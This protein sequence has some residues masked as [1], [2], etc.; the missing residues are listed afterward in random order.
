MPILEKLSKHKHV[1]TALV[2]RGA[3]NLGV[4]LAK[5]LIEQGAFVILIDEYTQ[6]KKR[7]VSS[8]LNKDLFSFVDIS[9]TKSI[10][11]S[12]VKLDYIFYLNHDVYEPDEKVTT[13]EFLEK[14][15]T[16]DRLLELGVEKNSRFLLTSSI[17][18]HEVLQSE[19]DA[20]LNV[21]LDDNSLSYTIL[22]VQRYAENLTWEYYKR[23]G[24]DTRIIRIGEILGEGIDLERRT[25][26]VQYINNAISGKKIQIEGDGLENLYFVYILDA[27][28]GL[29][30]AQFTAK[31][32]GKIYSLVIPRDITILNLAYKILDL[33]PRA[34][35]INFVDKKSKGEL[36]IYKPAKNLNVIGWK[37]R[38]SFERALANTIDFAYKVSGRKK[39]VEKVKKDALPIS[40]KLEG[41]KRGKKKKN[42]S[43]KDVFIN[44]FFEVKEETPARSVLDSIQYKSYKKGVLDDA[45]E[46]KVN[47]RVNLAD[48][49]DKKRPKRS[50]LRI[51]A[52]KI[53][54]LFEI[55]KNS[56]RSLTVWKL[57]SYLSAMMLFSVLYLLFFV[58]VAKVVY[59]SGVTYIRINSAFEASQDWQFTKASEDLNRV[60]L[61]LEK[62]E[63]NISKL[64]YL[65]V[66]GFY[67][68]VSEI[69]NKVVNSI[70][71]VKGSKIIIDSL[72]PL[73]EYMSTYQSNVALEGKEQL[74]VVKEID[75]LPA[76]R[77]GSLQDLETINTKLDRGQLILTNTGG[78]FDEDDFELPVVG[79]KLRGF[80]QQIDNISQYVEGVAD[81]V[82][83]MPTLLAVEEQ[84]TFVILLLDENHINIK[85]GEIVA[86]AV[87]N[88]DGGTI[89]DI[90]VYESFE[91]NVN[92]SPEQDRFV[93]ND[94]KL[95]YPE[96][97]LEF[98][99]LT[100][101]FDDDIFTTLVKSSIQSEFGEVPDNILTI[102][103]ESTRDLIS[104]IGGVNIEEV[105]MLN[106]TNFDKRILEDNLSYKELLAKVLDRIFQFKKEDISTFANFAKK[107]LLVQNI[108]LYTN[109]SSLEDC[110][111]GNGIL[112]E[113]IV[114]VYD[115]FNIAMISNSANLPVVE[116]ESKID[117]DGV[118]TYGEYKI[119]LEQTLENEFEGIVVVE[120]GEKFE[121]SDIKTSSDKVRL[122]SSYA[123]KIFINMLLEQGDEEYFVI[124]GRST[125]V[126]IQGDNEYSYSLL[127]KKPYGFT[128]NYDIIL[129]HGDDL[130]LVSAPS[131][132]IQIETTVNMRKG[133]SKDVLWM[134][135]FIPTVK[136]ED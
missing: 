9:G 133:I 25:L 7:K 4:E 101:M 51:V 55:V 97:G 5:L 136:S 131:D 89:S 50:R 24:L 3:N 2:F 19:K 60:Y 48:K 135:N 74:K 114:Q 117:L 39:G 33:E 122:S 134:F 76:V 103:L 96:E 93:R 65:S 21:D 115:R 109:D 44:F 116:V 40:S 45:G 8:L 105:G 127:F 120:C 81:V 34:E 121:I 112:L 72:I 90:Q 84:E 82:Y 20:S 129:D 67:E 102:N 35:G 70:N 128:Y 69:Q 42:K 125:D 100:L 10:A 111:V 27:A 66:F 86:I 43:L 62:V 123:D 71:V 18:L 30:K 37:P 32:S 80:Q 15:N 46:S 78:L 132:G 14:S 126:V 16:L 119:S 11:D 107:H 63:E 53:V 17:K 13:S 36:C 57:L 85:G 130:M 22:E 64:S 47:S 124:K 49:K 83:I 38:V 73:E 79:S 59:Y 113:D 12:I 1:P 75:S 31:T 68:S 91:I 92:L 28:Y 26:L 99:D 110:L 56:I 118:D 95:I 52:W 77:H 29:I 88:L 98:K 23:G 61:S 106:S 6:K 104:L 94:L 108:M 41:R 54:D 58:P 87:F